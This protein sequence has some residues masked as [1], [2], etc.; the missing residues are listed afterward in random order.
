[1]VSEA[2]VSDVATISAVLELM[3]TLAS[4]VAEGV[5]RNGELGGTDPPVD[6]SS[7]IGPMVV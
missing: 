5:V 3:A 1:V 2:S 7:A 6:T 4:S